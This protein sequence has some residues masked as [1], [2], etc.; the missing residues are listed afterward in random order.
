ML[1]TI[2]RCRGTTCTS[3]GTIRSGGIHVYVGTCHTHV[4]QALYAPPAYLY[5]TRYPQIKHTPF[6]TLIWRFENVGMDIASHNVTL[7]WAAASKRLAKYA[8]FIFLNSS[9]R[10]PFVPNYLPL[11]WRWPDAFTRLLVGDVKVG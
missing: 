4:H 9:A 5:T 8:Y 1:G 2:E 11:G 10:G 3:T 7:E 6:L